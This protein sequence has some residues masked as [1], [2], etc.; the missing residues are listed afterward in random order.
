MPNSLLARL[1][2]PAV[3]LSVLIPLATPAGA[4][5]QPIRLGQPAATSAAPAYA[6]ADPALSALRAEIAALKAEIARIKNDIAAQE[7]ARKSLA[8][9]H[10]SMAAKV[11]SVYKDFY[12]HQH[13]QNFLSVSNVPGEKG[14]VNT[15]L[16]IMPV[17]PPISTC[18]PKTPPPGKAPGTMRWDDRY[19]CSPPAP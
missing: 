14:G 2:M 4:Q 3:A 16:G 13:H 12:S 1:A 10:F 7:N 5:N 18:V 11:N 17:S 15:S 6:P 8:T 9:Q 19:A